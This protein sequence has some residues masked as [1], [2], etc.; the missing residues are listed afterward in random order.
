MAGRGDCGIGG[1]ARPPLAAFG[2]A[3]IEGVEDGSGAAAVPAARDGKTKAELRLPYD[4][5]PPV[6]AIED[7]QTAAAKAGWAK[8]AR[9]R[10]DKELADR[11]AEDKPRITLA[12]SPGQV[13]DF[14]LERLELGQSREQAEAALPKGRSY[15]IKPV[16]GGLSVLILNNS[17]DPVAYSRRRR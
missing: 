13:N 11:L 9:Q 2:P 15:R 16:P 3:S 8:E 14:S 7:T 12:R 4:D 6:F 1:E 10:D 17:E 5:K